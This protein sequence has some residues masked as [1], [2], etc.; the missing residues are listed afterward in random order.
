MIK[1]LNMSD[2]QHVSGGAKSC[3]PFSLEGGEVC[4]SPALDVSQFYSARIGDGLIDPWYC[5]GQ[6]QA[7]LDGRGKGVYAVGI[8]PPGASIVMVCDSTRS[9]DHCRGAVSIN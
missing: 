5:N 6:R 1:L 8:C 2:V 9:E 3:I 7:A 4:A